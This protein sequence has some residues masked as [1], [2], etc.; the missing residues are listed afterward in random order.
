MSTYH[1]IELALTGLAVATLMAGVKEL[2]LRP[3]LRDEDQGY[4]IVSFHYPQHPR[5]VFE[6]F[7]A[8]LNDKGCVIYP[9]KVSNAD[10]F[11]IGN[12]GRIFEADMHCV[13]HAIQETLA[14]MGIALA[15][16]LCQ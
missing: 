5:F 8:R 10:C 3:Y 1:A 7:Y 11:R 14:E 15:G 16:R 4:I 12:I 13:L 2:G 9:G 6:E